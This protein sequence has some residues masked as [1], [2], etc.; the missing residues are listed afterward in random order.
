MSLKPDLNLLMFWDKQKPDITNKV[1]LDFFKIP[2]IEHSYDHKMSAVPTWDGEK[3][4]FP[5]SANEK[6]FGWVIHEIAHMII[7]PKES[8]RKHNYGLGADPGGGAD[9][10]D[11]GPYLVSVLDDETIACFLDIFI[12]EKL[13]LESGIPK[14]LD[15]YN[16]YLNSGE[17]KMIE[18][19][20]LS[21]G[22]PIKIIMDCYKK[23]V[24]F[25]LDT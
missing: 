24:P 4:F 14:H 20:L 16:I 2:Y 7:T 21:N 1:I 23:Y 19:A 22:F 25:P 9:C 15:E 5:N 13:G 10:D 6:D 18:E 8:F 17:L 11:T 12:F 3:L